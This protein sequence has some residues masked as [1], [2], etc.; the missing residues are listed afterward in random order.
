M[1]MKSANRMYGS[2]YSIVDDGMSFYKCT[3]SS[4]EIVEEFRSAASHAS[5]WNQMDYRLQYSKFER[6]NRKMA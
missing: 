1:K 2:N 6:T 5:I 3:L 4:I